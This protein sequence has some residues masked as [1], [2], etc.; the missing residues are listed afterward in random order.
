VYVCH[1]R[2]CQRCIAAVVHSGCAYPKS[3][4]RIEGDN[5][6]YERD[7]NSGFKMRFYFCP[8]AAGSNV[9]WEG[10]RIPN[11]YGIKVGSFTDPNF[12]PPTYPAWEE[13]M[14]LWLGVTT[15]TEHSRR[16]VLRPVDPPLDDQK[17]YQSL[18]S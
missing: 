18:S 16:V 3:Q 10:D 7:A 13:V 5:R 12:P 11:T 9:F 4:V 14:H 1:C 6:I 17:S 15:A 2:A 8:N